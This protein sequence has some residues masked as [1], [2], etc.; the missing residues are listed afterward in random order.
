MAWS[1]VKSV[2]AFMNTNGGE[3]LIGIDDTGQPVGIEEDYAFVHSH[4]RD[5]WELWL[6]DLI[7]TTLGKVEAADVTPRYCEVD[8]KTV[9]YIKLT[10][11][12]KPV[13]ATPTK[14]ARPK[15]ATFGPNKPFYIRMANATQQLAGDE[16]L[17]YTNKHWPTR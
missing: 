13:F 2:A 16:L 7:S 14:A 1:V 12:S 6:G 15:G 17:S 9:A 10:R 4:N 11:A 8:G 5:G 3:L